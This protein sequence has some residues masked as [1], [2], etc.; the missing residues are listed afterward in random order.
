MQRELRFLPSPGRGDMDARLSELLTELSTNPVMQGTVAALCTFILED[1]TT[2]ACALLVADGQMTFLTALIGLSIGIA[3]GDWGLYAF[4]RFVGPKTVAWGLVT[5]RRLDRA[6][7]WF[8]RNLVAAIFISRF[9]PGLRLPTNVGAGMMQASL[10]RYLPVAL[11]ASLIWTAVTLAFISKLG[12]LLLPYVGPLKWPLGVLLVLFFVWVQFRSVRS[13]ETEVGDDEHEE[14]VASMFEFWPP[15][16]FYVP[17]A[18]YCFWLGLR[19]RSLTLPTSANPLIYSGGMIRESKSEIL[20]QVAAEHRHWI[21]PFVCFPK[22]AGDTISELVN[23]CKEMLRLAELTLPVVGKPDEGQRGAGVRPLYT[24][25]Q[26]ARYLEEFP[27]GQRICFQQLIPYPHEAGIF[28]YRFPSWERGRITS[29]TL[30]EFPS[31][32]GDGQSSIRELIEADPRARFMKATFFRRHQDELKLIPPAGEP[33]QLVFAGNHKQGAVFRDGRHIL[34]PALEGRIEEIARAIPEYY[35][36]RFD[37]RFASLESFQRGE[38]FRIVEINGAGA[39]STHIWAP[40][41]RLGDAYKDLFEQFRV[42][43]AI[44]DA[45]RKRGYRP[46]PVVHFLKDVVRYHKVAKHYPLTH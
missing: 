4:G 14:P 40:D 46:L 6:G 42:L 37:I 23:G 35:F 16:V 17:V 2:V 28:Y 5:Q 29:I 22:R 27:A 20:N 26:L 10:A 19:Y 30:K 36:G 15:I 41:A 43:Y 39:E 13:V 32:I 9:I 7:A 12:E 31:V 24:E 25:E 8:E 33:F 11:V 34:T 45:N 21:A 18:L 44:G 1:P 3:V 38:E